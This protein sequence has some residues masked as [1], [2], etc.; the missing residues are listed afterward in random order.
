MPFHFYQY[1]PLSVFEISLH[2]QFLRVF[3]LLLS[4]PH[5]YGI[6]LA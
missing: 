4:W 6:I 3:Q 1:I 2:L 5:S